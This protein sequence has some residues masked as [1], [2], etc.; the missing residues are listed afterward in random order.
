VFFLKKAKRIISVLIA[1]CMLIQLMSV[2]SLGATSVVTGLGWD[3]SEPGA[4]Y[5]NL[6]DGADTYYVRVYKDGVQVDGNWYFTNEEELTEGKVYYTSYIYQFPVWGNGRYTFD[7]RT[8]NSD[9]LTINNDAVLSPAY[10]Y[11]MP[12]QVSAP[13]NLSFSDGWLNWSCSDVNVDHYEVVWAYDY[14]DNVY[15]MMW[16][17]YCEDT[18]LEVFDDV[19]EYYNECLESWDS[20]DY[21]SEDGR[22]FAIVYSVPSDRTE[23]EMNRT[24]IHIADGI[25]DGV[26]GTTEE[27]RDYYEVY[28]D[29]TIARIGGELKFEDIHTLTDDEDILFSLIYNSDHYDSADFDRNDPEIVFIDDDGEEY[30]FTYESSPLKI[31]TYGGWYDGVYVQDEFDIS[32]EIPDELRKGVYKVIMKLTAPA[33][34]AAV[35]PVKP[36]HFIIEECTLLYNS[37]GSGGSGSGSVVTGPDKSVVSDKYYDAAKVTYDL[38]F[39]PD[40]YTTYADTVTREEL[41]YALISFL[42]LEESAKAAAN[43]SGYSD[44]QQGTYLNGCANVLKAKGVL[45]GYSSAQFAPGEAPKYIEVLKT[46][47]S[48]LDY[49]EYASQMGGY[50]MGYLSAA[51][52]I[53]LSKNISKN[54]TDTITGEEL[55]QIVFNGLNCKLLDVS[56]TINGPIYEITDN[57]LLYTYGYEKYVGEVRISGETVVLNGKKY[58]GTYPTGTGVENCSLSIKDID[59][60]NYDDNGMTLYTLSNE[61]LSALPYY[62]ASA[63]VNNG[64][65]VTEATEVEIKLNTIGY[66]KYSINDGEFALIPESKIVTH[67]LSDECGPKEIKITFAS[68]DETKTTTLTKTIT[69]KQA[70]TIT[71]VSEGSVYSTQTLSCGEAI[72]ALEALPE[73]EN[74]EFVCWNN[75]PEVMPHESIRVTA[76]YNFVATLPNQTAAPGSEAVILNL[77][78]I[79]PETMVRGLD[80]ASDMYAENILKD[81]LFTF[82]DGTNT[83]TSSAKASPLKCETNGYNL[84]IPVPEE[85]AEGTYTLTAELDIAENKYSKAAKPFVFTVEEFIVSDSAGGGSDV[86]EPDR[87]VISDAYY[88]AAKVVYD[89][90]FM[91]DIYNNYNENV[92][93]EEFTYAF[94]KFAGLEEDAQMAQDEEIF[95]DLETGTYLN[96]CAAV[97]YNRGLYSGH[98]NGTFSPDAELTLMEVIKPIVEFMGYA[99]YVASKGGYP[100][101]YMA[102]ASLI[103]LTRNISLDFDSTITNEILAEII[104]KALI[105]EIFNVSARPSPI[106]YIHGYEVYEGSYELYDTVVITGKMYS[107]DLPSGMDV[108]GAAFTYLDSDI[109]DY[110]DN[111]ITAYVK[112]G[113]VVCGVPYYWGDTMI[114]NN[115]YQ[116]KVRDVPVKFNVIGYTKYSINGSDF[117]PI[118][119]SGVVTYTLP[120]ECKNNLITIRLASTNEKYIGNFTEYQMLRVPHKITYMS[121]GEVYSEGTYYCEVSITPPADP[122]K[123]GYEFT[124][125][126]NLPETMPHGDITVNALFKEIITEEPGEGETENNV[127]FN[128]ADTVTLELISGAAVSIVSEDNENEYKAVSDENGKVSVDIE[129]GKYSVYV[130]ANGY[131]PRKFA[132]EKTDANRSFTVYL[133]K[134]P[135][136]NVETVIKEMTKQEMEDAGIDVDSEGNKHVYKC[137]TVLKFEPVPGDGS[138]EITPVEINF[139]YFCDDKGSIIK[140]DPIRTEGKIIYPVAKDIYLIVHS[141]VTWLKEMFDVELIVANTSVAETMETCK[142]ELSLPKGLSLADMAEGKQSLTADLGN[143]LPGTASNTHWYIRGDEKGEYILS[144]N[145]TGTRVGGG[146][147]EPVQ[148]GFITGEPICVLA[149]DAMELNIKA[150]KLAKPG[151]PYRM[152]YVLKNVSHKTVYDVVLSVLGGKFC[153]AYSVQQIIHNGEILDK[154]NLGGSF[155]GGK[156]LKSE[157]FMP[158]DVLSGVFEIIFG[159]GTDT[160]EDTYYMV[161]EMYNFVGAGST[162]VIPTTIELVDDVEVHNYDEGAVIKPATCTERGVIKYKCTDEGCTHT[163]E[164][165]I[166]MLSHEYGSWITEKEATCISEGLKTQYCVNCNHGITIDV[167]KGDH[168]WNEGTIVIPSNETSKGLKKYTCIFCGAVKGVELE[169][170]TNRG[171]RGVQV[172]LPE[173]P[174]NQNGTIINREN[175]KDLKSV[176]IVVSNFSGEETNGRFFA[177]FYDEQGKIV[178]V[179]TVSETI[180]SENTEVT[181]PVSVAP[182]GAVSMKIM[183]WKNEG[184]FRPLSASEEFPLN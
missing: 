138:V 142:A 169:A 99:S 8:V 128:F 151:E 115:N 156:E 71:Y 6:S 122:E 25:I 5:Y 154:E 137:T 104:Y 43:D 9:D 149:G 42:K 80:Y 92:T 162:T 117:A 85:I 11:V 10:D 109:D 144:G 165:P 182:V 76:M 96:G 18:G 57:T 1:V 143:I 50:P 54:Q 111:G 34:K 108:T 129:N 134:N 87:T 39:M 97:M 163:K 26:G 51:A 66:T 173:T 83:Y 95:T 79:V 16:G 86:T 4:L 46:F 140:A 135:L 21:P 37:G 121:D 56:Y 32:L 13:T 136:V 59:T 84:Y 52:G 33:G 176:E 31:K 103:G 90:G 53:G 150:E 82:T 131:E 114:N 73:V 88:D 36:I 133:N 148:N 14:G 178:S 28:L 174:V 62:S 23:Y 35:D 2:V 91:E 155:N 61:I 75:L 152:E 126:D 44:I 47:I 180:T 20:E 15:N 167:P 98:E 67:T 118:P 17:E 159:T 146:I 30:S 123:E 161:T 94:I 113:E 55:A 69:L 175:A 100:E 48:C 105:G 147:T 72:P 166:S 124:G 158:G 116:S 127:E 141:E 74:C 132:I 171:S 160:E 102:A 145:V 153:E 63:V 65:T 68:T 130:V 40:I 60:Y 81:A 172:Y 29:N 157:E 106:I 7:V 45:S 77:Q 12:N 110:V 3:A 107:A 93:R 41:A 184:S 120:D 181:I 70:H 58:N 164:E 179:G 27:T 89:L 168:T 139:D 24:V 78:D 125:W 22:L 177:V 101:G 38:G 19:Y 170:G 119:E 183:V 49:A 64:N 112:N